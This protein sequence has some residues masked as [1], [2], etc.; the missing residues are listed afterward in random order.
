MTLLSTTTSRFLALCV[1]GLTG[2]AADKAQ[3]SSLFTFANANSANTSQSWTVNG[4]TLTVSGYY[5]PNAPKGTNS[6]DTDPTG[7]APVDLYYNSTGDGSPT[8]GNVPGLGLVSNVLNVNHVIPNNGFIQ[9]QFSTP[10]SSLN[11]NM[12]GVTDK[13]YLY[14]SNTAGALGTV[15]YNTPTNGDNGSFTIPVT[16]YNYYDVISSVDCE[17]LISSVTATVAT[18]EPSSLGLIGFALAGLGLV[19]CQ[20]K[21]ARKG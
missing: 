19:R 12:E 2:L 7:N 5:D 20:A 21:K 3:A 8:G 9:L 14:G 13:W 1:L 10:V 15:I 11:L 6:P 17:S 18:P 16:K 4:L